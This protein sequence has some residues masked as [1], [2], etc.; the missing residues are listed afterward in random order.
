MSRD[1]RLFLEDMRASCQKKGRGALTF[2]CSLKI[3]EWNSVSDTKSLLKQT[4]RNLSSSVLSVHFLC[5]P[6]NSILRKG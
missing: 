3:T 2:I 1:N 5:Q 4:G 6:E